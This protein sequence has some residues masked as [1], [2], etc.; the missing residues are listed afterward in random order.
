LLLEPGMM[1][2]DQFVEF[3]LPAPPSQSSSVIAKG[4]TNGW[5]PNA[6]TPVVLTAGLA[7]SQFAALYAENG[8]T[9]GELKSSRRIAFCPS[10]FAGCAALAGWL[11]PWARATPERT[12]ALARSLFSIM[13][14]KVFNEVL[15]RLP[16]VVCLWP[17]GE[18][19]GPSG[20]SLNTAQK[21]ATTRQKD[22][23]AR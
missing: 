23:L 3:Q 4:R 8:R 16:S 21:R 19:R 17:P 18:F 5:K 14:A 22:L 13:F 2:V 15:I 20:G 12:R 1:P 7:A 9:S 11:A 10:W 6:C